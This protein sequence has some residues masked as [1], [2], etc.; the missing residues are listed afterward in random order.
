MT[1]CLQLLLAPASMYLPHPH[2]LRLLKHGVADYGLEGW[3]ESRHAAVGISQS[4]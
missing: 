3:R 4:P 2:L 1:L